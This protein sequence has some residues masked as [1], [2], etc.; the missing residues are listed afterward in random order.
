M[1]CTVS[2]V[3]PRRRWVECADFRHA[4]AEP[5]ASAPAVHETVATLCG[6]QAEVVAATPGRPAPECPYC[7]IRWRQLDSIA[8]RVA[9]R[10]SRRPSRENGL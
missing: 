6:E 9:H 1:T 8:Q 10:A 2:G 7:D 4:T 3:T 5:T